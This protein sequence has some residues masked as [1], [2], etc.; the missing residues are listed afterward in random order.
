M[1]ELQHQAI[2][3]HCRALRMPTIGGQFAQLADAANNQDD[4]DALFASLK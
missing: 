3:Q 1:S 2:R 4:I